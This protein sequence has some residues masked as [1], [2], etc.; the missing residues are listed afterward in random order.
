M[1][2]LDDDTVR[3]AL[4]RL[5]GW[6]G[7]TSAI[8]R[9]IEAP[10]FRT[11]V[12]IVDDVAQAAESVNHHPDIDIRWRSITFTLASHDAGGVTQAD[13]DLASIIDGIADRYGS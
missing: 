1:T 7:D 10:D 13:I 8:T 12:R 11:G 5:S 3:L 4:T 9:T 2:L 6:T